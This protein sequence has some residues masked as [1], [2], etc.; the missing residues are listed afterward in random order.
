MHESWDVSQDTREKAAELA[1][2]DAKEC[3]DELAKR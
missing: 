3:I 2:I 1:V